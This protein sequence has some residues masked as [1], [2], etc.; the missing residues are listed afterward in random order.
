M[1]RR[2]RP[3]QACTGT[4][5]EQLA[6]PAIVPIVETTWHHIRLV[7]ERFATTRIGVAT[8]IPPRPR[9][10]VPLGRI[11][12]AL[13]FLVGQRTEAKTAIVSGDTSMLKVGIIPEPIS[14]PLDRRH[15]L[16]AMGTPV[17]LVPV[18]QVFV[19][20]PVEMALFRGWNALTG[21][22]V[23]APTIAGVIVRRTIPIRRSRRNRSARWRQPLLTA[24]P[25]AAQ[26]IVIPVGRVP[27]RT[28]VVIAGTALVPATITGTANVCAC[29]GISA[30]TVIR[31][32]V[33]RSG[34]PAKVAVRRTALAIRPGIRRHAAIVGKHRHGRQNRQAAPGQNSLRE[35][36]VLRCSEELNLA[37][38]RCQ[39][40]APAREKV[41]GNN[42]L[43]TDQGFDSAFLLARSLNNHNAGRP[44][45]RQAK[46]AFAPVWRRCRSKTAA[47]QAWW[48]PKSGERRAMPSQ[49]KRLGSPSP[50]L[51]RIPR[52]GAFFCTLAAALLLAPPAADARALAFFF[53]TFFVAADCPLPVGV[54]LGPAERTADASGATG[55]FAGGW[56]AGFRS[57]LLADSAP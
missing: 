19:P 48:L 46:G 11:T 32:G 43:Y 35:F 1:A 56:G 53:A 17:T 28:L 34:V 27:L 10:R 20:A 36:H 40:T 4:A 21:T 8:L 57:A 15:P 23:F 39:R 51:S 31:T 54:V 29:S 5:D 26:L 33:A 50:V 45:R 41:D 38:W 55:A 14:W 42:R 12:A 24:A 6:P 52:R 2:P 3:E 13:E 47:W 49:S 18:A 16:I 7:S 37:D 44:P 9:K 30:D 22:A 25:A